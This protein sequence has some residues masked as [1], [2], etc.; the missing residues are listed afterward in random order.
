MNYQSFKYFK[1]PMIMQKL[2]RIL[3]VIPYLTKKE[4]QLNT[5]ELK[6]LDQLLK[7]PCGLS[8]L[9]LR[10]Q[11][12]I[13]KLELIFQGLLLSLKKLKYICLFLT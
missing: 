12:S 3:L 5:L 7:L 11:G 10:T 4:G 8:Y 2:G 13:H 1:M 6:F 9:L